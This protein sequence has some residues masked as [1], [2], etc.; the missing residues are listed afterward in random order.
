MSLNVSAPAAVQHARLQAG[1]RGG[2]VGRGGGLRGRGEGCV[3]S[4]GHT[5]P[6]HD[7]KNRG[8]TRRCVRSAANGVRH[9]HVRA[10]KRQAWGVKDAAGQ[11]HEDK[12]RVVTGCEGR[13]SITVASG[14]GSQRRTEEERR[15][16]TKRR[17]LSRGLRKESAAPSHTLP[18][19]RGLPLP[20][21][22][23]PPRG[24]AGS[25][26][27]STSALCC[28]RAAS[29]SCRA[30]DEGGDEA[31][32]PAATPP[33]GGDAGVAAPRSGLGATTTA[34]KRAEAP[35]GS[36]DSGDRVV[37][38]VGVPPRS[39]AAAGDA[40]AA[41]LNPNATYDAAEKL[42]ARPLAFRDAADAGGRPEAMESGAAATGV[43]AWRSTRPG[44][45]RGVAAG[46]GVP[47]AAAP[48]LKVG[49]SAASRASG[50]VVS[51]AGPGVTEGAATT[52][53]A[54]DDPTQRP[55]GPPA[56]DAAGDD[57]GVARGGRTGLL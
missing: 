10:S 51:A 55:P 25:A 6:A 40:A 36:T 44:V 22:P 8:G 24:V 9:P 39:R 28:A 45:P 14:V 38:A 23:L 29:S 49:P 34:V 57:A 12:K 31:A 54:G 13:K 32:A 19:L 52:L 27:A 46:A 43:W 3:S 37:A 11:T 1:A 7:N 50:L 18:A 5:H 41:A 20:S 56:T 17:R 2:V 42:G 53:G 33:L 21:L 48:G 16:S 35:P 15:A 30:E 4:G 47:G 26:T